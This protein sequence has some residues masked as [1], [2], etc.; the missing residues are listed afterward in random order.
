MAKV[1]IVGGGATGVALLW[2]LAQDHKVRRELQVTV[3]HD[4]PGLGGHSTTVPV[5]H[6]GK[7]FQVDIGVQFLSTLLY[8]N[9]ATMLELDEF[10][11]VP[12][13]PFDEL[14]VAC[15]FPPDPVTGAAR[16]WVNFPDPADGPGNGF[17]DAAMLADAK[18]FQEFIRSSVCRGWYDRT[19]AEFFAK[20]PIELADKQR[21][22]DYFVA[23]YMSIMNGYG[24]AQ[25]DQVK[26]VDLVALYSVV[27]FY[28]TPLGSFTQPGKGWSQFGGGSSSWIRAMRDQAVAK[29]KTDLRLSAR[30]TAVWTDVTTDGSPVHVAWTD[31]D[32]THEE[33][34]DKVVLTTDMDTCAT[35]L[36]TGSART[37]NTFWRDLYQRYV[38]TGWPLLPGACY[39]H[40]DDSILSPDLASRQE[41]LQFT[42][43]YA[44]ADT[45][46]GYDLGRTFTTFLLK[47]L[48][49]DEDADGLYL[50]MYG[51]T[52][53]DTRMPD[54]AKVLHSQTWTHGMWAATFM[55]G[56]K[57]TLHLA[58]GRGRHCPDDQPDT[59][60][61]F[62]GNNTTTDSEEGALD[63]AMAIAHYVFGA[64]YPLG[65]N[66]SY[67]LALPMYW[68]FYCLMFPHL[69]VEHRLATLMS[70]HPHQPR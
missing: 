26:F 35:L 20:P 63:S 5:E 6:N 9:V 59:N 65:V 69:S 16:N 60:V 17:Y 70:M 51:D 15:A 33:V 36:R 28:Q 57:K 11:D 8:P 19:L 58:Q 21:F 7:V 14:K 30:A 48:L 37:D 18:A 39:I 29:I 12:V 41:T 49:R 27:P 45:A 23:P 40:T 61:Y 68:F 64:C 56:P 66:P 46:P 34:F 25:L 24:S 44:E 67:P 43:Y 10:T 50:T 4:E 42:A 55:G 54:P 3:L 32:G 1:C 53:E 38:A 22:V 13:T 31:P 2:T 47:N 52:T 62:A